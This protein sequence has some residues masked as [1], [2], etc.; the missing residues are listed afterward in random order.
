MHWTTPTA[1]DIRLGFEILKPAALRRALAAHGQALV[2]RA[3]V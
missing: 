3:G 1:T 2:A